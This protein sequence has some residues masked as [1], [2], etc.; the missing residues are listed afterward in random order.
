MLNTLNFLILFFYLTV[1]YRTVHNII[2]ILIADI[3][4]ALKEGLQA[5]FDMFDPAGTGS[6]TSKNIAKFYSQFGSHWFK[7]VVE[8]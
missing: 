2:A 1:M 7:Y 3:P 5:A 8:L 6:I 4:F